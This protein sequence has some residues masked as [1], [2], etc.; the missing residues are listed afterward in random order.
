MKEMIH[1]AANE[2]YEKLSSII[3]DS[4]N[5][6]D[7]LIYIQKSEKAEGQPISKTEALEIVNELIVK[8]EIVDSKI[9]ESAKWIRAIKNLS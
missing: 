6:N 8:S 5:L 4:E 3:E 2:A 7:L 9:H 1:L